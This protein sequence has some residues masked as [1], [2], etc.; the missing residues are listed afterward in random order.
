M[1]N[2]L[3]TANRRANWGEICH[4]GV[5]VDAQAPGTDGAENIID[6][7]LP[8]VYL[9]WTAQNDAFLLSSTDKAIYAVSF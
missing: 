4:S 6:F 9:L 2:I 7:Q 8:L 1:A 3:Q 5:L